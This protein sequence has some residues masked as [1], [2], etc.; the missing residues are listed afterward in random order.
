MFVNNGKTGTAS[1]HWGG[2]AGGLGNQASGQIDQHAPTYDGRDAAAGT[3]PGAAGAPGAP[4]P[5][6]H[7]VL[8]REDGGRTVIDVNEGE[9]GRR[10]T[11]TIEYD[12][13]GHETRRTVVDDVPDGEGHV[14][15]T[16]LVTDANGHLVDRRTETVADTAAKGW[17]VAGSWHATVTRSY[18]GVPVGPNGSYFITAAA[19]ARIDRHEETHIAR[20]KSIHDAVITPL[21]DR[22]KLH[23]T[24]AKALFFGKVK[25]EP[26]AKVTALVDWDKSIK[27]F[28][29]QDTAANTPGGPVDTTDSGAADFYHDHGHFTDGAGNHFDHYVDVP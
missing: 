26:I 19:A 28:V 17:V 2:G 3:A 20:T 10:T 15:R 21:E 7:R 11:I 6:G 22:T 9:G 1:V 27:D 8:V 29:D 4:T 13:E 25:A 5:V 23:E 18:T 16:T 24:E 14:T 12:K